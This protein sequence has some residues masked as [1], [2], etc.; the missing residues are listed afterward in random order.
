MTE[1]IPETT[2][3]GDADDA[4][5]QGDGTPYGSETPGAE[6]AAGNEED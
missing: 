1:Q 3:A 5:V 4:P 2:Q 6:R